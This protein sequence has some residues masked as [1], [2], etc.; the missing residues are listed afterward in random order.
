MASAQADIELL[1]QFAQH[2]DADAFAQLVQRHAG[3]VYHASLRILRDPGRA[4][5]VSQETFYKLMRQP[6]RVNFCVGA[7]LHRAAT[8]LSLDI[9]RSESARQQ[10][11]RSHA[12]AEQ[13][14]RTPSQWHDLSPHIDDALARLPE[15]TRHLLVE[16]FLAG[17]SQRELARQWQVSP[18][19]LSRRMKLAMEAL[20]SELQRKDVAFSAVP[21]LAMLSPLAAEAAPATLLEELGKMAM[22]S[23]PGAGAV[24]GMPFGLGFKIG[25]TATGT[26][27]VGLAILAL[28][29]I[30]NSVAKHQPGPSE[31]Q[32][33]IAAAVAGALD[34]GKEL[35]PQKNADIFAPAGQSIFVVI[36]DATGDMASDRIT[37]FAQPHSQNQPISVVYSDGHVVSM[38]LD[39]ARQHIEKQ[40][41]QSLE[42]LIAQQPKINTTSNG[43][44]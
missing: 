7:W 20:R 5:D 24:G 33:A 17:K 21:L 42:Y 16:H 2:G 3:L 40:T 4:E 27:V 23:G 44:K 37:M 25:V 1:Q 15:A 38:P 22:L 19:T 14:R 35:N 32:A 30:G 26:V 29:G 6:E 12:I 43:N 39:Q 41:G 31:H 8:R 10:R 36:D 34:P 9:L 13:R 28:T 18:A 11:E